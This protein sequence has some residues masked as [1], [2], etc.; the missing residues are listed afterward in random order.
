MLVRGKTCVKKLENITWATCLF[1]ERNNECCAGDFYIG[2]AV[3]T[4]PIHTP[5]T[6]GL[7]TELQR[8]IVDARFGRFSQKIVTFN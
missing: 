5:L 1:V 3:W 7:T 8:Y 2:N 6:S 4:D